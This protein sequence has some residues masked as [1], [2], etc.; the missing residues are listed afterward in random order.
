MK[1]LKNRPINNYNEIVPLLDFTCLSA[2][3]IPDTFYHLQI[4]K[5]KK[6][7]P[8][9]G[10]NSVVIKTYYVSSLAYLAGIM[11]EVICLC[12]FHN[13]RACIN[14]NRRSFEQVAFQTLRKVADQIMNRDFKSAR[15]AYNSVCGTYSAEPDK[16][17]IVDIDTKD[18]IIAAG[19]L[20]TI[21]DCDPVGYKLYTTLNTK[22]GI[23]LI[24]KPFNIAQFKAANWYVDIHRDNPT[25]LYCPVT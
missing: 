23:H 9:L 14:L 20:M 17:W 15:N 8:E 7:H 3:G 2:N 13:A 1:S 19:I 22:N 18:S 12:D 11:S 5:R 25:I 24:T 21:D 6:E 4:I 16:K 10:S